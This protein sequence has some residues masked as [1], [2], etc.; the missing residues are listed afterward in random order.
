M[1]SKI[2]VFGKLVLTDIVIGK[3]IIKNLTLDAFG[4]GHQT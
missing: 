2:L 4:F 1:N 3:M